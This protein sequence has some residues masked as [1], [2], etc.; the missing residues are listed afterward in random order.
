MSIAHK[1]ACCSLFSS[2][3]FPGEAKL[4]EM[5][6]CFYLSLF[7]P[8]LPEAVGEAGS[9]LRSTERLSV[10]RSAENAFMGLSRNK[11][12]SIFGSFW[13]GTK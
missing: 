3:S 11:L 7:A 13:L 2:V 10:R 6:V 9:N 4:T 1:G 12:L 8:S 5:C